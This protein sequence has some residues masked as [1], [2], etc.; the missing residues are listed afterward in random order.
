[1]KNKILLLLLI[2]LVSIPIYSFAQ[3][4]IDMEIPSF[5]GVPFKSTKEQVK[6]LMSEK[7]DCIFGAFDN[8][9]N[10]L[11]YL[12]GNFN[13]YKVASSGFQFY[14]DCFYSG[15]VLLESTS[16]TFVITNYKTLKKDLTT[17]YTLPTLDI[18]NY[19]FPF[20]KGDSEQIEAI[21]L[22]KAD[23]RSQWIFKHATILITIDSDLKIM[24]GYSDSMIKDIVDKLEN[25]DN[26]KDL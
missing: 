22:G 10:T 16:E 15:L 7:S 6:K 9:S 25:K 5:W 18:E 8:E 3:Y 26:S 2:L 20:K 19:K 14:N 23:F 1:M 11:I 4:K 21:R 17:K 13:G 24:V 12:G